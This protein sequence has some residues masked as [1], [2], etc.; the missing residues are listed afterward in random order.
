MNIIIILILF[1]SIL[2]LFNIGNLKE[3]FDIV[4]NNVYSVFEAPYKSDYDT[5][6][7]VYI[8]DLSLQPVSN[9]NCCLVE[10]EYLPDSNNEFGGQF[11]YTFNKLSNDK[12]DSKLY[13]LDAN[14]QLLIDGENNWSNNLCTNNKLNPKPD[15]VIGSCRNVN[16]EC[17]DFVDKPFCDNYKMVWSER[18]CNQPLD[19]T[20]LDRINRNLPKLPTTE[21]VVFFDTEIKQ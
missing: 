7:P 10:K 21:T 18:T 11:K 19:Y 5:S 20:W 16:K 4:G 3:S 15:L 17:I 6:K 9:I 14:K 2:F 1:I 13:K 8:N 12:C